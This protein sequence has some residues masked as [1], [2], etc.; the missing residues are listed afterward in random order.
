MKIYYFDLY[1]RAE[2]TRMMLSKAGVVYEDCR[3]TGS[4][5]KELKESGV[6][7]YG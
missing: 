5:W 7:E 6:L 4:L 2:A 1:A 3:L